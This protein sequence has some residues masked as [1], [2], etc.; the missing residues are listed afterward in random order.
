MNHP[1]RA[2]ASLDEWGREDVAVAT[3]LL[4]DRLVLRWWTLDDF[5]ALIARS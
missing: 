3:R 5:D 2:D 4:T 1:G